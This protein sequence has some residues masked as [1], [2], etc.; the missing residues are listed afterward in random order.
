MFRVIFILFLIVVGV[1][2]TAAA[3]IETRCGLLH[4]PQVCFSSNVF[5]IWCLA[6]SSLLIAFF[7]LMKSKI[8]VS[9]THLT[10]P[11]IYSV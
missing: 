1:I 3:V 9:Y 4:Y 8:A 11:T 2:S 10:L 5:M 6:F 7:L